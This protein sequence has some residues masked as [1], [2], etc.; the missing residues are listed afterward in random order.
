MPRA[1]F[2]TA[3]LFVF[4]LVLAAGTAPTVT[5][6]STPV[7]HTASNATAASDSNGR[8][9]P[10]S[11]DELAVSGRSNRASGHVVVVELRRSD[12][13]VARSTDAVVVNG[14]W[15]TTLDLVGVPPGSYTLRVTDGD[16]TS[17]APVAIVVT[18]TPTDT[19]FETPATV[20][21]PADTSTSTLT[22]TAR[23]MPTTMPIPSPV[24]TL[25]QS[26]GFRVRV[27]VVAFALCVAVLGW[28][29]RE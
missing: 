8:R 19:P 22:P 21:A 11:V 16:V 4:V 1:G 26:P 3:L 5:A 29:R 13:T 23:P 12:G 24:P 27:A 2:T 25:A 20:P 9:V 15:N 14:T 10:A 28:R 6:D 18:P 17:S 7:V